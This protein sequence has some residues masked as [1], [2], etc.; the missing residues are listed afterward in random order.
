MRH[1]KGSVAVLYM[2]HMA[3]FTIHSLWSIIGLNWCVSSRMIWFSSHQWL[4]WVI[5]V[6]S[7]Q[8]FIKLQLGWGFFLTLLIWSLCRGADEVQG[9][10]GSLDSATH[11][12]P[13]CLSALVQQSSKAI[14]P[15]K[16]N[17]AS[18]Q[19]TVPLG[20][21][22]FLSLINPIKQ[23]LNS[24][25]SPHL[26]FSNPS[27]QP[28]SFHVIPSLCSRMLYCLAVLKTSKRFAYTASVCSSLLLTHLQL[29]MHVGV[30]G[31]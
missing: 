4:R 2:Q 31:L 19:T 3:F 12:Q 17:I 29:F 20:M 10:D 18:C 23:H 13:T 24:T 15:P 30:L 1:G 25:T 6:Q 7:R 9:E 14:K 22:S 28:H 21:T 26:F 8:E 11:K 16:L 27:T 5:D